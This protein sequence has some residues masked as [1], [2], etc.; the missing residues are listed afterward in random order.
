MGR[1]KH[2]VRLALGCALLALAGCATAPVTSL[3]DRIPPPPKDAA[4]AQ[5]RCG[6]HEDTGLSGLMD[7]LAAYQ[8]RENDRLFKLMSAAH[9]QPE[10]AADYAKLHPQA[11]RA[12]VDRQTAI[13]QEARELDVRED[14]DAGAALR[15]LN[16]ALSDVDGAERSGLG[17]CLRVQ[18]GG[19]WVPD[20]AC[21]APVRAEA[22]DA[23]VA[24]ADRYL[25]AA[26]GVWQSWRADTD[27]TIADWSVFPADTPDPDSAYV[28]M[29]LSGYRQTQDLTVRQLMSGSTN[30]CALAV[31]AV[32]RPEPKP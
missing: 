1:S 10:S 7:D 16:Q 28:Q 32:K 14:Q 18:Q 30:L 5:A 15:E 11:A 9:D 6:D 12:L 21:A 24:A 27:K 3:V 31:Q 22:E 13:T 20:P 4:A 2:I 26:Q 23:R 17:K 29:A 19:Q 8:R 25:A